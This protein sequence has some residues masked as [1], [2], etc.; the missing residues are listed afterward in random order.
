MKLVMSK[1]HVTHLSRPASPRLELV[2][3]LIL[4]RLINSVKDA[5][6]PICEVEV[7]QCW[8]D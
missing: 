8:T 5:L 6:S 3:C 2:S 7:S 4:A 1:T